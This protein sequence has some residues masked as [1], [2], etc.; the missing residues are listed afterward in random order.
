[1]IT[2]EGMVT[3]QPG[4]A[5]KSGIKSVSWVTTQ[6]QSYSLDVLTIA[7]Q[8]G[9]NV[10]TSLV[11]LKQNKDKEISKRLGFSIF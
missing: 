11:G 9:G 5:E 2:S 6:K 1:M 8:T 3:L 7:L 10:F 4:E